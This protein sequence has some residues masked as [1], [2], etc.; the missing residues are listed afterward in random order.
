MRLRSGAV[1]AA[2]KWAGVNK[3]DVGDMIYKLSKDYEANESLSTY[4]PGGEDYIEFTNERITKWVK[5]KNQDIVN[6]I[7]RRQMEELGL[8]D[9]DTFFQ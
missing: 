7:R 2:P 1:T 9:F 5:Q 4:T 6:I 3:K 8:G